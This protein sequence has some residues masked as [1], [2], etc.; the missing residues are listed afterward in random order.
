MDWKK[1]EPQTSEATFWDFEKNPD[2][3]G[4]FKNVKKEVGENKSNIY[5]VEVK[6]EDYK[7]WGTTVLDIRLEN[8]EEGAEV[9]IKYLG[10]EKSKKTGREYKN[11]EVYHR[12]TEDMPEEDGIPVINE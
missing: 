7:F 1:I 3:V 6:G 11:Y 5:T 4:I 12:P 2:L 9:W 10:R 8:I